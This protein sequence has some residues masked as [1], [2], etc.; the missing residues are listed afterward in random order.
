MP[1]L[2]MFLIILILCFAA[3]QPA[4][5]QTSYEALPPGD[6]ANGEALFTENTNEAPACS[7]CHQID[8]PGTLAP[9]LLGYGARAGQRVNGQSAGEYT[10][11]SIIR[12]ARHIVTPFSNVMYSDYEAKLTAQQIADL[13]AYMLGL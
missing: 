7:S 9:A 2:W 4:P 10:Y 6:A 8:G 5:P 13:I 12:P 3:C 11:L 1:R